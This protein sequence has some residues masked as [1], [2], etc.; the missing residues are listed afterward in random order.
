MDKKPHFHRF[1]RRKRRAE[2]M[3]ACCGLRV[4]GINRVL[5]FQKF[6]VKPWHEF[7]K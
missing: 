3:C 4:C 7:V 1:A 6:G 5:L 2:K